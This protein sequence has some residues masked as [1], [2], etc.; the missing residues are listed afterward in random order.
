M[1]DSYDKFLDEAFALDDS[2]IREF[3][4]DYFATPNLNYYDLRDGNESEQLAIKVLFDEES[5]PFEE[6]IEEARKYDPYNME[7]AYI[8]HRLASDEEAYYELKTF[9]DQKDEYD[10]LTD[11]QKKE[12][13]EIIYLYMQY[14]NDIHSV[15]KT[16]EIM[17]TITSLKGRMSEADVA[18]YAYLYAV[19]EDSEEFYTLY[20][21]QIFTNALPYLLLIEVLLKNDEDDKAKEVLNDMLIHI[22]YSDY[23]DHIWDLENVDSEEARMFVF[24]FDTCYDELC[25]V[26]YYFNWCRRN[27]ERMLLS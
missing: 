4:V 1:F 16:L 8:A 23:V 2:E 11:Y 25:S 5:V 14:M 27:K 13:L 9:Y 24:A 15:R 10:T 17:K 22:P 6:R 7:A 20:L 19:L 21:N 12:Y 18:R 26:P 3:L